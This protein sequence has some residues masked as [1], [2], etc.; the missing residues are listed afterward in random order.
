MDRHGRLIT[1]FASVGRRPVVFFLAYSLQKIRL[2][3]RTRRLEFVRQ[4]PAL[5]DM[6]IRQQL[7]PPS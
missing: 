3:V 1:D 7:K 4:L 6:A 2:N 5:G